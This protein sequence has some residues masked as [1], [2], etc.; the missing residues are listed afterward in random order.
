M[1]AAAKDV[2]LDR[3]PVSFENRLLCKDGSYRWFLWS[4]VSS[5]EPRLIYG[6]AVD[7]TRRKSVEEKLESSQDELRRL[8]GYLQKV[9]EQDRTTIARDL[10]DEL[11]QQLSTLQIDITCLETQLLPGQEKIAQ[12]LREMEQQLD[13]S[14]RT[15]QRIAT[16]LRPSLLDDLGLAAAIEWQAK[17]FTK[18]THISCPTSIHPEPMAVDPELS[19]A[20]F[21]ILQETLTNVAR[22]AK[23]T[24]VRIEVR[25]DGGGATLEVRDNGRGIEPRELS[26]PQSLGL[27]GMRERIRP[28][29]GTLE[30]IGKPGQGTTVRVFV[31]STG[32]ARP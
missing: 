22:H 26:S 11:G 14:I 17:D 13:A 19:T 27:I 31:P 8:A 12:G 2:A 29:E 9:R 5:K 25:Q 6:V 32:G 10:H 24:E 3:E 21:R 7:I 18:H 30:I 15:V 28:W 1:E 20:L 16:G 4:V 23:A